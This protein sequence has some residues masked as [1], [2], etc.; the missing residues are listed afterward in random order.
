MIETS[1]AWFEDADAMIA[2]ARERTARKNT[3]FHKLF[4]SRPLAE[5]RRGIDLFQALQYR[6]AVETL[7]ENVL[8]RQ[9]SPDYFHMALC[10][11]VRAYARAGKLSHAERLFRELENI[12]IPSSYQLTAAKMMSEVRRDLTECRRRFSSDSLPSV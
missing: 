9:V 3:L 5:L 12:P 4:Q 8:A 7:A 2:L 11:I 10:Y 1:R 6:D